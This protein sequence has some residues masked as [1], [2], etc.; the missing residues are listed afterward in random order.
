MLRY[1]G[2][3][4]ADVGVATLSAFCE[5]PD[6][7]TL[8]KKDLLKVANFLE[9]EYFSGKLLSYLTC[10]F[11]NAA[12]VQP[13][14]QP[15]AKIKMKSE[16]IA[17]FKR[18]VLYAF[19]EPPDPHASGLRCIF[20]GEPASR[21]VYRQHVP[22]IT[23]EDVLNFF[24]AGT[25]G[26]PI[27]GAYLLAIQA[28]PM[29]ARRCYGRALAVHCPDD[30]KLTYAFAHRFLNDN[31]KL[32]LLTDKSKEKYL[33]A[34]APKTLI[35]HVLLE[36][37]HE[38][39]EWSE[40]EPAP[41]VTVYHLTNSGQGPDIDLFQL[42]SEVVKFIRAVSRAGTSQVWQKIQSSARERTSED[43]KQKKSK[44]RKKHKQATNTHGEKP[45]NPEMN[46]NYLYDDLFD[47]PANAARFVRTY[48][49]R[50]A[51]RFARE[52]DP[53]RDYHLTRQ[54]DLVS[55]DITRLFLKEVI[56]MEK[57]RIEA[58][59]SLGDRV[60]QHIALDNDRRLFQG[61]YRANRYV[62]LRNLLIKASNVR[63]KKGQPPLLGLDEFLLVFEEGEEL[64][65]TDWTLA[66]DLVL[67]RVIEELHRQ[68]WF[69]K[70]P[71][72]LQELETEDEAANLAAS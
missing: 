27:S 65:R 60:A 37:E 52:S 62:I 64:A 23:G 56:G 24:P 3:P 41:S 47:L 25:G 39:R 31:R 32:L 1:T 68:G 61:L 4:I 8:T 17:Q 22:M 2:H 20:S 63:L 49:L 59:R 5:K 11:P 19:Q 10:V 34:K 28:F 54:F 38:R 71:D 67:I 7:S 50:Q 14:A 43:D 48:F 55:W 9:K 13:G 44:G 26:L 46:R 45:W 36:I 53:R 15:G 57:S 69:G 66:R 40:D 16:N 12:Y 29:G 58:I 33:D 72:A 21:I 42:P 51:H 30:P 35:V 6:P 70:Q 18:Q